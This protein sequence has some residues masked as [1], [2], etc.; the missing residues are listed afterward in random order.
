MTVAKPDLGVVRLQRQRIGQISRRLY[1]NLGLG[2]FSKVYGVVG[3]R[4]SYPKAGGIGER[5][6][7]RSIFTL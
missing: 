2:F 1:F 6:S 5:G 7:S 4:R 3:R